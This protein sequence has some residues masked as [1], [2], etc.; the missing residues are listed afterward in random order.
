MYYVFS[1]VTKK[2]ELTDISPHMRLEIQQFQRSDSGFSCHVLQ[3]FE[4]RAA[5][6][7]ELCADV[8]QRLARASELFTCDALVQFLPQYSLTLLQQVQVIPAESNQINF[9]HT[10]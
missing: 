6:L 5:V 7:V 3:D 2:T 10:S 1:S 9:N 4:T 8:K